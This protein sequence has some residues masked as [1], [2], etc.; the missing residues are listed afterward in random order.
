MAR[1]APALSPSELAPMTP[2]ETRYLR[3]LVAAE[4]KADGEERLE[5]VK[6]L[7]RSN[8]ARLI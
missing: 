8:G 2:E 4:V 6:A 7:M 5:Y 1:N 3:G